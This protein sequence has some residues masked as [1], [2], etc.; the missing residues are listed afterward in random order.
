M[1]EYIC[2]F[3]IVNSGKHCVINKHCVVCN[4]EVA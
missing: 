3:A 2:G 4:V 1:I